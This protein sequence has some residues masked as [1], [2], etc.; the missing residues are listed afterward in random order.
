MNEFDIKAAGWDQNPMHIERSAA[1]VKEL[2]RQVK[3]S[4]G[5]TAMEYGAGTGIASFMLK[6]LI[7]EIVMMDSSEEMVRIMNEKIKSSGATNL[8]PVL[9]DLEKKEWTGKKF[10][11]LFNQMVMHHVENLDI[12]FK[13]FH[14]IIL[15]TG[16]LAVADIYTEDGSFHG[17]GFKGHLGFD[18]D[19]LAERL[20]KNGFANV[21]SRKCF[22]ISKK[23]SEAETKYFN[24]FLMIAYRPAD[25]V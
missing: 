17:E 16:Y 19:I 6:D 2:L 10:N 4:R 13:R 20:R 18:T 8:K 12:I 23:I 24:V 3:V 22:T 25:K 5:M 21:S 15:P 1:I 9:F 7:G 11:L 14:D